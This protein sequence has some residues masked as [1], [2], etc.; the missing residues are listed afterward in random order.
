[1]I[2]IRTLRIV[3]PCETA[4]IK[5]RLPDCTGL[6]TLSIWPLE[7]PF[8]ALIACPQVHSL[9]RL[10][11]TTDLLICVRSRKTPCLEALE[12]LR[13]IDAHEDDGAMSMFGDD[14]AELT[15]FTVRSYSVVCFLVLI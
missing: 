6:S 15:R 1:M 7:N 5:Q 2:V 10:T 14:V 13:L 3:S 12:E 4:S 8:A 9:T 11:L